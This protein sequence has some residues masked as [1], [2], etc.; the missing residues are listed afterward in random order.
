M[1]DSLVSARARETPTQAV[2][3]AILE[4]TW[5]ASCRTVPPVDTHHGL[6][7][8]DVLGLR[9]CVERGEVEFLRQI[10]F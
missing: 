1:A 6:C 7:R 9:F 5:R 10:A 8:N 4:S 2:K 3:E